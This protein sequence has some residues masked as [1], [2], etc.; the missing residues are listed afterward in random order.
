MRHAAKWTGSLHPSRRRPVHGR[1]GGSTPSGR[2]VAALVLSA[3]V[4][5]P[6]FAGGAQRSEAPLGYE[7]SRWWD[8]VEEIEHRFVDGGKWKKGLRETVE[9]ID[10]VTR[11]SWDESDLGEVF[12]ALDVLRA[13]FESALGHEEA[14][15]WSV[16]SALNLDPS[17]LERLERY[18]DRGD[19]LRGI[20]LRE[21][22]RL[23]DGTRP[24]PRFAT[25]GYEPVEVVEEPSMGDFV[26]VRAEQ[27]RL[28][29]VTVEVVIGVDGRPRHPVVV[30][31]WVNPVVVHW[32]LERIRTADFEI[33][34]ARIDG[35]PVVEL[36]EIEMDFERAG[37]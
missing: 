19:P 12:A 14:A 34:P 9:L 27:E 10:R 26:N 31:T 3:L 32:T 20:S 28:P 13:V 25:A 11:R 15:R 7:G 8:D 22:G 4:A 21:K 6:L 1:A 17:V 23:P 16:H 2:L 37:T 18:G 35:E 30:S 36:E 33:R 24:P 29:G 5:G